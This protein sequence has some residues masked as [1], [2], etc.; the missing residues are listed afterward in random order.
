M[1]S[2][3]A[4]LFAIG[5]TFAACA[6]KADKPRYTNVG[7]GCEGC[8]AI[9]Q[10][11]PAVLNEVDTLPDFNQPGPK[12]LVFGTIYMH[13][14]KTP[15]ANTVLYIYHTDQ[16]GLYSPA[17]NQTG[18]A[19]RHGAL[20]GWIKTNAN[21]QY[22]FY[23]LRPAPYPKANIPAHIHPIVREPDV[24][25]Y[26]IDE[27]RFSDDPLLTAQEKARDENRGGSGVVTLTKEGNLLMCKRDIVLGLN[28][29]NY[30]KK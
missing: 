29:P 25:E 20:R 13:D 14:G 23:T 21:G 9:Y 7:G 18:V 2:A 3:I 11:M 4:M 26:Y 12:M 16:S 6:Q 15:A 27:Y 28:I 22:K 5:C 1:K 19:K 24:N 10:D 8:Q 17:P 30:P